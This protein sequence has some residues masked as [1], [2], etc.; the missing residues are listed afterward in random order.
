MSA[1]PKYLCNQRGLSTPNTKALNDMLRYIDTL[2]AIASA[3]R[4][5]DRCATENALVA[6]DE[7]F[8]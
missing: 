8:R 3:A 1:E 4:M 6:H 2:K 5:G 7:A